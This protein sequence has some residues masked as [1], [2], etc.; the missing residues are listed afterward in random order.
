VTATTR[1]SELLISALGSG[2]A[3]LL[4]DEGISEIRLNSD[5][6]VWANRLGQGK[7]KTSVTI[8]QENARRAI[9]AVAYG[10]GEVCND[11]KPSIS[12]EL[13]GTGERFQGVLPPLA[14]APLFVIR[15]KAVKIFS[16]EELNEQGILPVGG[17]ELLRDAVLA[18][19]NILVVG[20]TDS[21][22]TTFTNALLRVI[23]DTNDRLIILEDTQE[24]Q[25]RANDVEYLHTKDAVASLRDLIRYTMRMSPDRIVIGEVRGPE[26]LDLLKA[27]NTGHPGGVS[28]VHANSAERGLLRIEQLV[29]EAGV[30]PCREMIAEAV[31]VIVYMQKEGTKRKVKNIMNVRGV[32]GGQYDLTPL[33]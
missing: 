11:N 6:S 10:V 31:N 4:Q 16:L 33:I 30:Q 19:K 21:G 5:G 17:L 32:S 20:G 28:T 18:R 3:A 2:I 23:E 22:K 7:S 15:K 9:Y 13:P 27:W 12:A 8:S 26:A 1:L 25:C 29:Q 24:L 14:Q